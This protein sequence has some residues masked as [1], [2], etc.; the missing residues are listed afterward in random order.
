MAGYA[1]NVGGGN[2]LNVDPMAEFQ[3]GGDRGKASLF[4]KLAG[5]AMSAPQDQRQGLYGQMAGMDAA[6]TMDYQ[7]ANSALD[8]DKLKQFA[9][10][11]SMASA[12]FKSGNQQMAQGLYTSLI[13]HA[14][15]VFGSGFEP[16]PQMDAQAAQAF[17]TL[18]AAVSGHGMDPTN[19]MKNY[20]AKVKDP[21]FGVFLG[22]TKSTQL[23]QIDYTDP[24][25]GQTYKVPIQWDGHTAR[26]MQGNP[27]TLPG[28]QQGMQ[29]MPNMGG[30]PAPVAPNE[31]AVIAQANAMTQAHVPQAQV[32][33][34]VKQ[35]MHPSGVVS[36]PAPSGMGGM[37][38]PQAAP[39]PGMG[40]MPSMSPPPAQAG[41][42][43]APPASMGGMS[44]MPPQGPQAAPQGAPMGAMPS[45][46]RMGGS[47][48]AAPMGA[49]PPQAPQQGASPPMGAMPSA[50]M[51]GGGMGGMGQQPSRL[52]FGAMLQAKP[53]SA[54]VERIAIARAM[55]IPEPQIQAM[56]TG[57]DLMGASG[58]DG[59]TEAGQSLISSAMSHGYTLPIPAIGS[60]M[61]GTKARVNAV[62]ALGAQ[63]E[64]SGRTFDQAIE[65]MI[66]GK[67]AMSG[68]TGLQKTYASVAGWE[69]SASAQ[70]DIALELSSK[71]GRTGVPIFNA[72][73]L[74]GRQATGDVD[75][76]NFIQAN[77]ALAEEYAKVMSSGTGSA[78]AT[79]SAR[80]L[81][82]KQIDSAQTEEQYVSKVALLRREMAA[83]TG[84]LKQTITAQ[85]AS[86]MGK[87]GNAMSAGPQ[88]QM[89]KQ[90]V[91]QHITDARAAI[92]AGANKEAVRQR[93]I[94]MGLKNSAGLL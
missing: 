83:R 71:A 81:A 72:W 79:D 4:N 76:S 57:G 49:M 94:K 90:E 50:G 78:A 7:K 36:A 63:V 67:S 75:V 66:Q 34:W 65:M 86:V 38:A 10:R 29:G 23:T 21:A 58:M 31:S 92:K 40:G 87:D 12:A 20:A 13:P 60:G 28:G 51:G 80:T 5:Q 82:H 85:R 39:S 64:A 91:L 88:A 54:L 16:P 6:K 45:G 69:A 32:D 70:A 41:P 19:E 55:H 27:I 24:G 25:T 61:A 46:A 8:E 84:A 93:L 2:L 3:A 77:N 33:A 14:K 30:Q 48:Q 62:N 15:E 73:L 44:G 26:D 17:D 42:Q 37:G 53:Q 74:A 52:P 22:D 56:V 47:A 35:Q 68:L 59:M 89:S 18:Q 11:A 9:Q 43:G 1:F